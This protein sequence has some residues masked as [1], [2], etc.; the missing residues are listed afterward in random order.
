M[1]MATFIALA[2]F[3]DKGIQNVK[4]TTKRADAVKKAGK[5]YGV[6][7]REIF[8][9]LGNYDMVVI[10]EADNDAAMTSFGLSIGAAGNVRTTTLRAFNADEMNGI[11]A[12]LP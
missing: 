6:N 8:W 2:N 11:L 5:K 12:K 1:I 3:T 9:T 7:M 4:E 10:F